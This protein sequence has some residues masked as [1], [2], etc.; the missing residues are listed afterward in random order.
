MCKLKRVI[1]KILM[2]LLFII[3]ILGVIFGIAF[4]V[5]E[6]TLNKSLSQFDGKIYYGVSVGGVDVGG[7]TEAEAVLAVKTQLVNSLENKI[8]EL[9]VEDSKFTYSYKDFNM[10]YGVEKA[11]SEAI[12]YGKDFSVEE[13]TKLVNKMLGEEHNISLE[14]KADDDAL[15]EKENEIKEKIE[16]E[17]EDATV[18]IEDGQVKII[19]EVIGLSIDDDTFC[20]SI[21]DSLDDKDY[22]ISRINIST[23]KQNPDILASDLQRINSKI[24]TYTT[25]YSSVD[26]N[27]KYNIEKS[28]NLINK[29]LLMPGEE[30]S[31]NSSVKDGDYKDAKIKIKNS[32][33]DVFAEGISQVSTTLYRAAMKSHLKSEE[34]HSSNYPVSYEAVGMEAI[35][36]LSNNDYKFKNTY[37]FPIYIESFTEGQYITVNLYGDLQGLNGKTYDI[38]NEIIKQIDQK[39]TYVDAPDLPLGTEVTEYEG[40][41]EYVVNCYLVTYDNGTAVNKELISTDTYEPNDKIIKRGTNANPPTDSNI[42]NNTDATNNNL[43]KPNDQTQNNQVPNVNA[44]H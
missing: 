38:Q 18:Q 11:V 14:I 24:S 29:K 39:T 8:I 25:G 16:R 17:P 2:R 13:K 31:F 43:H 5:Y 37:D 27:V 42:Q 28:S 23:K 15:K 9:S 10:D 41:P 3:I 40:N 26:D 1:K 30:F 22:E 44:G 12:K 19:N 7:K 35:S 34:R 33:F 32:D 4:I 36:D 21:N 6:K 20:S